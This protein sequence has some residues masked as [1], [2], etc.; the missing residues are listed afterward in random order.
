MNNV[1]YVCTNGGRYEGYNENGE[2][3]SLLINIG[4]MVKIDFD[5]T[6]YNPYADVSTISFQK[7]SGCCNGDMYA[8][9]CTEH[10]VIYIKQNNIDKYFRPIIHKHLAAKLCED[11][12]KL[13]EFLKTLPIDS[14]KDVKDC[15]TSWLVIYV[16][17]GDDK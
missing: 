8:R 9:V 16:D 11:V 7:L 5:L 14:L 13:N 1:N 17:Q 12:D 6:P 3:F 2:R 4:D 15:K 10:S